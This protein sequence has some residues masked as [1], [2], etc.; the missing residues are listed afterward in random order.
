MWN[1]QK[2]EY[3]DKFK[4][5]IV[6]IQVVNQELGRSFFAKPV[7]NQIS[8][9]CTFKL[10][11]PNFVDILNEKAIIKTNINTSGIARNVRSID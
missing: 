1:K 6:T 10:L 4:A 11:R 3:L 9:R 2:F 5:K 8:C 7:S